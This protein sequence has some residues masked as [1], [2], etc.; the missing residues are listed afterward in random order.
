MVFWDPS[1]G[2]ILEVN[3]VTSDQSALRSCNFTKLL[4]GWIKQIG[5]LVRLQKNVYK[6]PL[7]LKHQQN[8]FKFYLGSSVT[9][10]TTS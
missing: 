6:L 8:L 2:L 3:E 10:Q 7:N 1:F 5:V 9:Y 4:P